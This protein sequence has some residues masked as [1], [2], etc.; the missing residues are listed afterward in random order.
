MIGRERA[1][2]GTCLIRQALVRAAAFCAWL[3]AVAIVGFA[4][5]LRATFASGGEVQGDMKT[6]LVTRVLDRNETY[7]IELGGTADE[8]NC[9]YPV[10]GYNFPR[11]QLRAQPNIM[12]RIENIGESDIVNPRLIVN[13]RRRTY[14]LRTFASDLVSDCDTL[15]EKSKKFFWWYIHQRVHSNNGSPENSQALIVLNSLGYMICGNNV[16]VMYQLWRRACMPGK[17]GYYKLGTRPTEGDWRGTDLGA[18]YTA[19]YFYDGRWRM[20]DG[21]VAVYY[22][23]RDNRTIASREQLHHD[24][25]LI[26]RAHFGTLTNVVT[27]LYAEKIVGLYR[28]DL[29]GMY[30]PMQN[31]IETWDLTLR[32]GESIEYRWDN[33][34]LYDRGRHVEKEIIDLVTGN[35]YWRYRPDLSK[36]FVRR[37]AAFKKNIAWPSDE[38]PAVTARDP[39]KPFQV[40]WRFHCPYYFV[41]GRVRIETTGPRNSTVA[42]QV[43]FGKKP[44]G[45]QDAGLLRGGG[46]G[47]FSLD[48][49]FESVAVHCH[50]IDVRLTGS[51]G[52]QLVG[53]E[54]E[55]DIQ[56]ALRSLPALTVGQNRIEYFDSTEGDK[57]VRITRQ[58]RPID[59]GRPP[60]PPARPIYPSDGGTADGLTFTF[61]WPEAKDRGGRRIIDYHFQLSDDPKF[62]WRLSSNFDRLTSLV[63]PAREGSLNEYRIPHD[64]L[65]NPRT[66]YYWR[67]RA[68]NDRGMWS[69]WSPTWS[70]TPTGPGVCTDLDACVDEH[71]GE[72]VLTWSDAKVGT[73]PVTYEVHGSDYQG[74]TASH[75]PAKRLKRWAIHH[76]LASGKPKVVE[77][78][79]WMTIPAT[80]IART[81][82]RQYR[83]APG[84]KWHAFYRVVPID[85]AGRRGGAS[86]YVRPARPYINA[87][88]ELHVRGLTVDLPL[89][90]VRSAG[91]LVHTQT[92]NTNLYLIGEADELTFR[93]VRGPGWLKVDKQTG[94]LTGTAPNRGKYRVEVKVTDQD[95]RTHTK[96]LYL[97][98]E[99]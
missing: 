21:N 82:Q 11:P 93:K 72:L 12:V 87:P 76:N 80:L 54:F 31:V 40:G 73:R 37:A 44:K 8:T 64:G 70:F 49:F 60:R 48:K 29:L 25:D 79:E 5:G 61:R 6:Q 32:P 98:I 18:H 84:E 2:A 92:P 65:L 51:G 77:E 24:H 13:G 71:S 1:G 88:R 15:A 38:V 57:K 55:G 75:E 86:D 42:V 94:R 43:R 47:T 23:L 33:R 62:R 22:L 20:L 9:G 36:D 63:E 59:R 41:G 53:F 83:I 27:P 34:G 58:F 7:T 85:R 81:R 52:A 56:L 97:L 66:K 95:K 99:D 67:V 10:C 78:P 74:L 89:A 68:M 17:K 4:Y 35:G 45:W 28:R 30:P 26:R 14:D 39:Q 90:H 3:S 96:A 50:D 46:G 91:H 16:H 69:D 19:E